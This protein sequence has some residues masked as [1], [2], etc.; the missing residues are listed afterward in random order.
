MSP[1]KA[2]PVDDRENQ[3]W[4]AIAVFEQIVQTIPNDRVS[5]E[6]LSHAY[7]QVGDHTRA[8]E[9]L[10][11]LANVLAD[12][13]DREAAEV[14]QDRLKRLAGTD[15]EAGEAQARIELLLSSPGGPATALAT[16]PV[17]PRGAAPAD[18]QTAFDVRRRGAPVAA[19]LSFAWTLFQAGELDQEEYAAVAQDLTELSASDKPV[20]ISVLHVLH[21]RGSRHLDRIMLYAARTCGIAILPLAS[22]DAQHDAFSLVPLEFMVRQG[23]VV[24]GLLGRDALVGILNPHNL[25]LRRDV[26]ILVGRRCH[27]YLAPPGEFD[28]MLETIRNRL[29][30]AAEPG[31]APTP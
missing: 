8:R 18:P 23:A 26:E 10:I 4:S 31:P 21:D 7:E 25:E 20:T 6:A 12:E 5:L 22:F 14:V 19:E 27:F 11:R 24:F 2:A 30:A 13:Q 17:V 1:E 15:L 29:V 28:A 3:V 9:Y 16:P